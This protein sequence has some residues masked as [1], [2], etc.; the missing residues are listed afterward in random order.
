EGPA[1]LVLVWLV[2]TTAALL[3]STP[4]EWQR[5]YLPL[6]PP[7][8]IVIGIGVWRIGV[9]TAQLVPWKRGQDVA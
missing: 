2:V 3:V 1:L 8:A 9:L 5:Y 4:F 6:Q 7:L